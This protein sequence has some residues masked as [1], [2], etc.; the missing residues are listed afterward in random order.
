[1]EGRGK[2]KLCG[3]ATNYAQPISQNYSA[4]KTRMWQI[5]ASYDDY[6]IENFSLLVVV[7]R[8][9]DVQREYSDRILSYQESLGPL[10]AFRDV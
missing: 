4:L 10:H 9:V 6:S 7:G 5:L 8:L 3:V 1:M 2:K